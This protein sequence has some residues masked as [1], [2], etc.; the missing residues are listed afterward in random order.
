M[1]EPVRSDS[2]NSLGE[3]G[4]HP[5][6]VLVFSWMRGKLAGRVGLAGLAALCAILAA[7]DFVLP[8]HGYGPLEELPFFFGVFGFAAF[9]IAVLSAWPLGRLLRRSETYYGD[10]V[11]DEGASGDSTPGDSTSVEST[12]G[13]SALGVRAREGAP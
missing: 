10:R 4:E 12:S 1:T 2:P 11:D 3:P 7:L 13:D 6:S 9:S 5:V 8:G